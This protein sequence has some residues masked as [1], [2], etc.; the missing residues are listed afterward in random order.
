MN[1]TGDVTSPRVSTSRSALGLVAHGWRLLVPAVIGNAVVQA[2]TAAPLATPEATWSVGLRVGGSALAVLIATI[3]VLSQLRA[4]ALGD[5]LW[6]PR[7]RLVWFVL[8]ASA[9]VIAATVL[10]WPLLIPATAA[11]VLV[12]APRPADVTWWSVFRVD[13]ARSVLLFAGTLL[14]LTL[15]VVGAFLSGF[16][17]SGR[18]S[19]LLVWVVVGAVVTLLVAAWTARACRGLAVPNRPAA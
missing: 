8:V 19:A 17:I 4:S 10:L 3:L 1:A 2:L 7:A 13:P 5:R 15:L 6:P 18:G 16:F 11:A 9:V 12:L 14:V